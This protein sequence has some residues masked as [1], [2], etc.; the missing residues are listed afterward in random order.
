MLAALEFLKIQSKAGTQNFARADTRNRDLGC[1]CRE[2]GRI[3]V[4]KKMLP[5][6]KEGRHHELELRNLSQFL[7]C[8]SPH[9]QRYHEL[10]LITNSHCFHVNLGIQRH[11]KTLQIQSQISLELAFFITASK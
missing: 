6:G 7:S 8:H 1:P 11:L 2:E 4:C 10:T 5:G 9:L 3:K